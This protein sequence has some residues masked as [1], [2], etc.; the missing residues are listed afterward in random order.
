MKHNGFYKEFSETLWIL[1]HSKLENVLNKIKL[2]S[3]F[4]VAWGSLKK[5]FWQIKVHR[6]VASVWQLEANNWSRFE[7]ELRDF[8]FIG[9][10]MSFIILEL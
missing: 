6:Y 10:L 4:R 3:N 8:F 2:G 1:N 5:L 9:E 7:S